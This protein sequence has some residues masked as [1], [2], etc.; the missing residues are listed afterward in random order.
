MSLFEKI[1]NAILHLS[2]AKKNVGYYLME[3]WLEAAFLPASRVARKAKV[4]ESVVVRFSQDLGYTGFPD[5]QKDLQEI[6]KSRLINPNAITNPN[7]EDSHDAD[8]EVRKV[9]D[10]SLTNLDNVF[11]KNTIQSFHEVIQYITNAKKILILARKNSYGPAYMLHVHI[12]EVFSKSQVMDGESVEILDVMKGLT[13][14]DLAIFISI[15]SYS[16]RM[17]QFSDYLVEKK[18]PQVAITNSYSNP[19]GKNANCTLLTS[20]NTLSFANSHMGTIFLIDVLFHLLTLE[21][22][23]NML[24]SLEEIKVLNERFGITFE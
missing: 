11:T 15:P 4:S 2:D 3:N 23:G 16:K 17:V 18:I 21:Q 12:N 8:D 10:V 24:K 5:L 20:V 6:L 14:E 19:F 1:Q 22:K 9:Y 7:P 13:E